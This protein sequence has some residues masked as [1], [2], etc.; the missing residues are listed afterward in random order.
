MSVSDGEEAVLLARRAVLG[1]WG[2]PPGAE[3]ARRLGPLFREPRGVFATWK[4]HPD[5]RLRGCV[6]YP[7]PVLP[8]GQAIEEVAVAAAVDDPR[9][10]PVSLSELANLCVEVSILTVPT[11]VS[12][13]DR[14]GSIRVGRDGVIVA[15]GRASGLLLPQVAVEERWTS[16]QL[17]DATCEKAGL[18]WGAW[19]SPDVRVETFRAEVFGERT[20]GGPVGRCDL[21]EPAPAAR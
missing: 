2:P 8:L 5:G 4:S 11:P 21:A 1:L 17:L 9:F 18:P 19:G 16:E 3:P 10:P 6:G 14:P 7:L 20:P 13:T 15:R 12:V